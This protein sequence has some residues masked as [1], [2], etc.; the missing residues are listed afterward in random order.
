MRGGDGA[1]SSRAGGGRA[2]T[3]DHRDVHRSR[4][5]WIRNGATSTATTA[6]RGHRASTSCRTCA[7]STS[8]AK[9][10]RSGSPTTCCARLAHFG[11][12]SLDRSDELEAAVLPAVHV[13]AAPRRAT[14]DRARPARRRR[15]G[16]PTTSRGCAACSI[17]SSRGPSGGTRTSPAGHAR[18][19]TGGSTGRTSSA[20]APR[21]RRTCATCWPPSP[22]PHRRRTRSTSSSPVRSRSCRSSPARIRSTG[23][24]TCSRCWRC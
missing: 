24:R 3:G 14:A 12:T 1:P 9:A 13:A 2:R 15:R 17:G 23:R 22:V 18:S 7:R 10:C 4:R 5:R 11:V 21:R 16:G 20:P 19:G 8:I 6:T